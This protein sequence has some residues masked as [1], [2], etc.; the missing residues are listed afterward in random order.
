MSG[1]VRGMTSRAAKLDRAELRRHRR[2]MTP[3]FEVIVECEL[4][5]SLDW[6]TGGVLLDGVC[7]GVEAGTPVEGWIALPG[8]REAFAFSG[9]VLRVDE[10]T[11]NTVVHF[12]DIEDETIAFLNRSIAWRLH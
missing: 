2:Y 6:S 3:I 4:F 7:E 12:D 11:G 5:R 8:S 1:D 10:G 9:R